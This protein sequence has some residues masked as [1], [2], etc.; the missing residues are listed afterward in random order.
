MALGCRAGYEYFSNIGTNGWCVKL[1]LTPH[2]DY[3]DA[4]LQC[5]SEGAQLIILD[6]FDKF[7][8]VMDKITRDYAGSITIE[9]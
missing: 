6:Q 4:Q 2:L 7:E 8:V 1:H 5:H 3:Y 9:N